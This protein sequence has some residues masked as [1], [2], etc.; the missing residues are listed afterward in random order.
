MQVYP[1]ELEAN[2]VLP[3]IRKEFCKAAVELGQ[4]QKDVAKLLG[5]TE[6]AASQYLKGKRGSELK[7][8]AEFK[9]IIKE[10][11]KKAISNKINAFEAIQLLE[12]K[13]RLSGRL[14]HL[15]NKLGGI[16]PETCGLEKVC[17]R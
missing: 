9:S 2:L 10:L 8:D 4:K 7:I 6:A 17:L 5:V 12:N 13:F 1:I 11:V 15:H 16:G 3:T 14:C